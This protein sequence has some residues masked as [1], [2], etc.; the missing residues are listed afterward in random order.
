MERAQRDGHLTHVAKGEVPVGVIQPDPDRFSR[1]GDTNDYVEIVVSV[2]IR[3]SDCHGAVNGLERDSTGQPAGDREF[4]AVRVSACTT[5]N[6][7]R[8]C[9]I[10]LP[11]HVEVADGSGPAERLGRV[12]QPECR[13]IQF[14][15]CG[16]SEV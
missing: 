1:D 4:E 16:E 12:T 3:D 9:D 11:I 13:T 7:I 8:D 14:A 10:G 15:E 6:V 5:A 2:D